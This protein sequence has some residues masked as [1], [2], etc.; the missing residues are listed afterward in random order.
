MLGSCPATNKKKRGNPSADYA[1]RPIEW[2]MSYNPWRVRKKGDESTINHWIIQD[3]ELTVTFFEIF[4]FSDHFDGRF[5]S[6]GQPKE[7]ILYPN[8]TAEYPVRYNN[9]LSPSRKSNS[10]PRSK[11][12]LGSLQLPDG[13][14]V[15]TRLSRKVRKKLEK[16]LW[17]Y[18][19]CPVIYR[20][21][22]LGLRY[23]PRW[24]KQ[25]R[26]HANQSCSFP[27][28]MSCRASEEREVVILRWH[29]Q[30]WDPPRFCKWIPLHYPIVRQCTCG[31]SASTKS[32]NWIIISNFYLFLNYPTIGFENTRKAQTVAFP[33]S[34]KL[35][36]K[37][38][39]LAFQ[40]G[41]RWNK[42]QN[43]SPS[44]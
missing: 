22:D 42:K 32:I 36:E 13:T 26:C 30:Y 1:F 3:F 31:C 14:R 6:I 39:L 28:G 27:P 34:Q 43:R 40:T 23:W 7:A 12:N 44:M 37:L 38:K 29:C 19:Q 2:L 33:P 25:G 9:N 24:I 5:M 41:Q 15:R 35:W 11:W 20:W 8:G 21:K 16:F 10:S 4:S 18:T 17:L